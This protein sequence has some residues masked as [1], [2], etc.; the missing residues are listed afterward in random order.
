LAVSKAVITAGGLGTRLLPATKEI[1][2]EM[3]PVYA[4][5]STGDIVLKPVI[6]VIFETLYGLGVR[7]F[8]IV[9]GRGKRALED[10]FTPDWSFLDLLRERGK[11]GV[12]RDLES[13]YRMVESSTILWVRQPKPLGFGH[14]VYMAKYFVG[15]EAFI[16]AAAD[17]VVYP[18]SYLKAM[19]EAYNGGSSGVL[20]LKPVENPRIYGV[21][22]VDGGRVLRVIEKPREP[23]SSLA[24]MPYYILPPEI[25]DVLGGLKPGVGGEIQLTDAIEVLIESGFTFKYVVLEDG[26]FADVGTPE[27]YMKALE[28]SYRY[29]REP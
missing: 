28:V 13:F 17:T 5:S 10:H 15:G 4:R 26:D 22:L 1:P 18:E 8:C 20:L 2:K 25:M 14:A 27:G 11:E 9:T 19:L 6:Q 12:A 16:L 23:P 3:L 21:A 29:A 24:I 7:S